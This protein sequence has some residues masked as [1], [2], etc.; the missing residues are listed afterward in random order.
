MQPDILRLMRLAVR[1]A[2]SADNS[3][4]WSLRGDGDQVVIDY[5]AV[6]MKETLFPKTHHATL[7][8]LGCAVE[9]LHQIAEAL[10]LQ[11]LPNAVSICT[12][13]AGILRFN[14]VSTTSPSAHIAVQGDLPLFK[15][16]TNRWPFK[17]ECIAPSF[18]TKWKAPAE[19]RVSIRIVESRA[20]ISSVASFTAQASQ[21]RF[22][23]REIHEWFAQS[24]RF[25]EAEVLHGD[26]L[27]VETLGLPP[28]GRTLLKAITSSWRNMS[29]FN[30][31]GGY[32]FLARTEAASI[33]K[34]GAIFAVV[35]AADPESVI[36]AGRQMQRLWIEL[37]A[38]GYAVQPYYVVTDQLQRLAAGTVPPPL[39]TKILKL[40]IAVQAFFQ[41]EPGQVVHMLLRV[42]V[43]LKGPKPAL[44]L[45]L[46]TSVG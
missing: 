46:A 4:P 14:I 13:D 11:L 6:R 27:D 36:D 35:G 22:Q 40:Q 38:A 41:L 20:D 8:A 26:G 24:L 1:A 12:G 9:N 30:R 19:A 44:R 32:R 7:L 45:S 21:V 10:G 31:V 25:T 42:G 43:P 23:T 15:R 39:I 5:E 29:M 18:C 3:Q 34:A 16:H 33:T 37:N 2:P 28:G 17:K